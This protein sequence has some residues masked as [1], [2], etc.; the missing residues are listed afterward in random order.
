MLSAARNKFFRHLVLE[1]L[2]R[3]RHGELRLLM[4][5]GASRLFGG[6]SKELQAEITVKD[7][8]FYSSCVLFGAIGFSESYLRGEWDTPNLTHAIAWFIL[9]GDYLSGVH[10]QKQNAGKFDL[11]GVLNRLQH[12]LRPNSKKRSRDNISDHYDLGND[13]FKLWLDPTMTYSSAYYT[14]PTD[15]LE[16]AQHA[17]WDQLCK[18]LRIGPHDYV[19]EIGCGWGGFAIHAAKNYGCRIQATTI[20]E[21]QFREAA[22]RVE[23]AGVADLVEIIF[24]DY[25][26]LKGRFDKIVSIEMLEAVGDR[27]VD[28]FFAKVEALLA[29]RGL[30]GLQMIL[31]PDNQYPILRDGVDFIQ[32]HIFPGSLLMSMR[33]ITEALDETGDLNLLDYEDMTACYARTLLEWRKAFIAALPEVRAQGYDQAFLRKWFYYLCYCEAGFGTHHI[34]I[35]QAIYTR[36]NN[37]DLKSPIYS[38]SESV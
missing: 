7:D 36:P 21:E 37:L 3:G 33:R 9:N 23:Q 12:L 29:P 30:L 32:K 8:A 31:C 15:T 28:I 25:R 6:L 24:C 22:A 34:S 2:S 20:S 27:Y 35:A 10:T 14:T 18:K 4:P 17:K 1:S 38:L 16:Q 19:L 5:G 11:L 13:F 26:D